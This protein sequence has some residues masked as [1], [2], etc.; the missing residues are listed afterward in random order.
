VHSFA[1]GREAGRQTEH[2]SHGGLLVVLCWRCVCVVS[3]S[4]NSVV[5]LLLLL[6]LLLRLLLLLSVIVISIATNIVVAVFVVAAGAKRLLERLLLGTFLGALVG[7]ALLVGLAETLETS[8]KLG[9]VE[10]RGGIERSGVV[11]G[12]RM[13]VFALELAKPRVHL[14]SALLNHNDFVTMR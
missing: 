1:F 2:G 11:G 3:S 8:L 7:E 14:V 4:V 13:Q 12:E 10:K 5:L 9:L 6:L